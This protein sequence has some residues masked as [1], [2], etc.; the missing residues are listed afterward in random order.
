MSQVLGKDFKI[1]SVHLVKLN[2][3]CA[4]KSYFLSIF[5]ISLV[6]SYLIEV[7]FAAKYGANFYNMG[8]IKENQTTK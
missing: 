4:P 2:L 8:F 5:I 3:D 7:S 6:L 1:L